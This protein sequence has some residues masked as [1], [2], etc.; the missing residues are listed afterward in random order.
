MV[1]SSTQ[2]P[3]SKS[4]NYNIYYY[5]INLILTHQRIYLN[6]FHWRRSTGNVHIFIGTST[7]SKSAF[8][9]PLQLFSVGVTRDG[10]NLNISIV[11]D[12][13]LMVEK[14]MNDLR[15]LTIRRGYATYMD[16]RHHE[17]SANI[18]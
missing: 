3:I 17:L 4:I 7:S 12:Q 10:L 14:L 16:T 8:H 11:L 18:Q 2:L 9:A 13:Y 6:F 1:A 5:Q 15:F